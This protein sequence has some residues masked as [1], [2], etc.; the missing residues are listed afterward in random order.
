MSFHDIDNRLTAT[1]TAKLL[2]Q[3]ELNYHKGDACM[4]Q[5]P[6]GNK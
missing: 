2:F 5:E 4:Y 6:A 3:L 1:D